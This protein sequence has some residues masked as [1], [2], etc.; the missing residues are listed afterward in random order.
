VR[1][2]THG[3]EVRGKQNLNVARKDLAKGRGQDQ[4]GS[5]V[6]SKIRGIRGGGGKYDVGIL[7]KVVGLGGRGRDSKTGPRYIQFILLN[8]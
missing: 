4:A 2:A 5:T 3:F 6:P 7:D 1:G 8:T